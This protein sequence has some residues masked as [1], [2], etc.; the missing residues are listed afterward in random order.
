MSSWETKNDQDELNVSSCSCMHV[1]YDRKYNFKFQRSS[2]YSN[3]SISNSYFT[4][5]LGT[6]GYFIMDFLENQLSWG[7]IQIYSF[8]QWNLSYIQLYL[9]YCWP[10]GMRPLFIIYINAFENNRSM[11]CTLFCQKTNFR[12]EW[13]MKQLQINLNVSARW[14]LWFP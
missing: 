4:K 14:L 3:D 2:A 12:W 6:I 1:I 13:I 11:H 5:I 10:F 8:P 7:V 9:I